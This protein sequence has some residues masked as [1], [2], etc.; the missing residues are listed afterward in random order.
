M[1][2]L[3]WPARS[4]DEVAAELRALWDAMDP[5][6]LAPGGPRW[7]AEYWP[8]RRRRILRRYHALLLTA[9]AML[10]VEAPPRSQWLAPDSRGGLFDDHT[11]FLLDEALRSAGFDPFAAEE[12]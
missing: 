3:R 2:V 10:E 1:Q 5:G 11:E 9:A 7:A 4:I 12:G 8:R 6:G